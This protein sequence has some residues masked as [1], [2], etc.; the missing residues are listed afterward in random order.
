MTKFEFT[1]KKV[2]RVWRIDEIV[3]DL[4]IFQRVIVAP[5]E[6]TAKQIAQAMVGEQITDAVEGWQIPRDPDGD[7]GNIVFRN[8]YEIG[9]GDVISVVE[10]TKESTMGELPEPIPNY[11][12]IWRRVGDK[13]KWHW[14]KGIIV[15]LYTIER[16]HRFREITE[17]DE[18]RVKDNSHSMPCK[19]VL[20]VIAIHHR[21]CQS[22]QEVE[23]FLRSLPA[24]T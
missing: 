12:Y 24:A 2:A 21:K 18:V 11:D 4:G 3:K 16:Y 14:F 9:L 1:F 17:I 22:Y 15:Q 5:D 8:K 13:L 20:G 6:N 23:S 7:I 10:T 19:H